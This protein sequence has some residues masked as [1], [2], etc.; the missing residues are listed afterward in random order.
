[1]AREKQKTMAA[2]MAKAVQEAVAK[3][4]SVNEVMHLIKEWNK[5]IDEYENLGGDACHSK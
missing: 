2:E 3:E 4:K 1:M 5:K